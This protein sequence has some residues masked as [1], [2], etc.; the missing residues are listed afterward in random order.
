MA[1]GGSEHESAAILRLAKT[2]ACKNLIRIFFLSERARKL[3]GD[4]LP[5]V[6]RAAVIGAGVM[7]SGIAQ[8]VAARGVNVLLKDIDVDCVARGMGNISKLF[9]IAVRKHAMNRIEA[10]DAADR[11]FP[12]AGDVPMD[13]VEFVLE[14][15]V[16]KLEPKKK[17][18]AS[19][20]APKAVLATNTSA[21]SITEI[22]AA[23]DDPARVVGFHFFNPVHSMQLV[24]VARGARTSDETVRRAVKFAHQIGKLPV[25]VKDSPGFL[26]NRILL[27]YLCEAGRL[28]ECGARIRDVDEAMLG[29]GMPM[30]PLRLI[31]E[32]GIDIANDVGVTLAKHLPERMELPPVLRRMTERGWLGRKSGRGFYVYH[33]KSHA[34][35]AAD[36]LRIDSSAVGLSC[37]DMKRRMVLLLVNESARCLEEGVVGEPDDVD[38]AMIMGTG[39]APFRGGPLRFADSLGIARIVDEM[40]ALGG[41]FAPCAL[42]SDMV[43]NRKN[44]YN[45]ETSKFG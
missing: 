33:G 12:I 25:V 36:A 20:R 37:R 28:F 41:I 35:S 27:P 18:F 3:G 19:L 5:R 7:G 1:G 9:R 15:A 11:I 13:R 10:R 8:W 30:G 22:A 4:P 31:D 26:I 17:I 32:V 40:N 24:E 34:N 38:F 45:D 44:F 21:L 2:E 16:E 39:F 43:R 42:L 14:A 6:E 29:F 23:T